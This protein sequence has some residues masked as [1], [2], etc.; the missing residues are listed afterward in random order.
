MTGGRCLF[1]AVVDEGGVT[2][3][4]LEGGRLFLVVEICLLF[5]E[6][7]ERFQCRLIIEYAFAISFI[8]ILFCVYKLGINDNL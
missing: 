5:N 2:S 7:F 6:F 4:V 8:F 1:V 3:A